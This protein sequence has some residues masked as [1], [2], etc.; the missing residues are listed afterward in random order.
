MLA[1]LT[2]VERRVAEA[3]AARTVS[4]GGTAV[5][6]PQDWWKLREA[7]LLALGGVADHLKDAAKAEAA[8][9]GAKAGAAG[10]GQGSVGARVRALL[11]GVMAHDLRV[12]GSEG[13]RLWWLMGAVLVTKLCW[14]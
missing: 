4:A 13:V 10:G 6:P 12:S 11:D 9:A 5:V 7:A 8:G 3:E 14:A 1:V 2:A